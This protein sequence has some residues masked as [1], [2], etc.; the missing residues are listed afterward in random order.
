MN[1]LPE[2]RASLYAQLAFAC[3]VLAVFTQLTFV[4]SLR[5]PPWRVVVTFT[6]AAPYV[7]L[8]TNCHHLLTEPAR[9]RWLSSYYVVQT[10]IVGTMIWISPSRG[11]FAILSLPQIGRA[12]V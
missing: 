3:V 10:L 8:F 2:P 11:F 4:D 9:R 1:W 12:H 5:G 7:I 6:L